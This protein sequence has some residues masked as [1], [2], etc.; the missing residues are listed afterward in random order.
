MQQTF[1]IILVSTVVSLAACRAEDEKDVVSF[2]TSIKPLLERQCVNCHNSNAMF[3]DLSLE[4]A[5][6]AF[7]TRSKEAVITPGS[8]EKSL[9]YQVLTLPRAELK[10]MPP[11]GHKIS[12]QDTEL[13]KRW[14]QQGAGWPK[15]ADGVIKPSP[16]DRLPGAA[17]S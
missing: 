2:A 13:V 17:A 15:G 9:L 6:H 12:P 7:K 8:P 16:T 14:I 4:N 1:L 5:E 3:G 10:S 11:T